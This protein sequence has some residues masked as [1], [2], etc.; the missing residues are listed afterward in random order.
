M[1]LIDLLVVL[2]YLVL[3]LLAHVTITVG[4]LA[5]LVLA[6]IIERVVVGGEGLAW[7][8]KRPTERVG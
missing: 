2:G 8:R 7:L 1:S 4:S 6:L 5:L 3:V